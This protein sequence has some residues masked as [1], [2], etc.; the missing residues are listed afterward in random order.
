MKYK[1]LKEGQVLKTFKGYSKMTIPMP[2]YCQTLSTLLMQQ[3]VCTDGKLKENSEIESDDVK[4]IKINNLTFDNFD[5]IKTN[6]I[7]LENYSFIIV[8]T[9]S[10]E[11]RIFQN[12]GG[13]F[14]ILKDYY[15]YLKNENDKVA[16]K[17]A[18][19]IIRKIYF[20]DRILRHFYPVEELM[21]ND[22]YDFVEFDR[23]IFTFE[24]DV[25]EATDIVNEQN[26]IDKKDSDNLQ[27]V[28]IV[29]KEFTELIEK[30]KGIS[31]QILS[32]KYIYLVNELYEEFNQ[33]IKKLN[34][35]KKNKMSLDNYQTLRNEMI[36]KIND[37]S[38]K[39]DEELNESLDYETMNNLVEELGSNINH[40]KKEKKMVLEKKI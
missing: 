35:S 29:L 13:R 3:V 25:K 39:L 32:G 17:K 12:I 14:W 27:I 36:I 21:E 11:S 28:K 30:V 1:V 22:K 20:K 16:L 18:K 34:K 19:K 6:N 9:L 31:D 5:A 4:T 38:I 15:V 37:L 23:G 33:R 26:E 2:N 8:F 10:E 7:Y 40:L 24:P